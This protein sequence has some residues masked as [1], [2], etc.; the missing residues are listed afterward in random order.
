MDPVIRVFT[1]LARLGV[2]NAEDY[3][4]NFSEVMANTKVSAT[5][6]KYVELNDGIRRVI[7]NLGGILIR[8]KR[9]VAIG[10]GGSAAIAMHALVD[11]SNAGG[12][13]TVDMMGPSLLTCMANDYGYENVFAKPISIFAEKGD[14]LFAISSSGKSPNIIKACQTAREKGSIVYTFSGFEATNPLRTEGFLNFYVPSTN[15]GFVELA[16]HA[17]IH[18]ICDLFLLEKKKAGGAD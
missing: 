4:R 2:D 3:L 1:E 16:H 11:Y 9:F 13:K 7:D 12:L 5:G 17:L 8:G 18:C 10:N 15:Y 6:G 14:V